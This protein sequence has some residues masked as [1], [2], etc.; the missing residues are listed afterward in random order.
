VAL[1]RWRYSG[2]VD[3]E[4]AR[5]AIAKIAAAAGTV[6]QDASSSVPPSTNRAHREPCRGRC[7][8]RGAEQHALSSTTIGVA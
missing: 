2:V 4:A 8:R 5:S 1:R 7:A 3:P 6:G